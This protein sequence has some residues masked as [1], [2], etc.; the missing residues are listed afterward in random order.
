M[1]EEI[2]NISYKGKD[3][4]KGSQADCY[5]DWY[6]IVNEFIIRGLQDKA[7]DGDIE[8]SVENEYNEGFIL[9]PYFT[10]GLMDSKIMK[11]P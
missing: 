1:T 6:S 3:V 9:V 7:V 10:R 4:P 11:A 2:N 8:Y 5:G